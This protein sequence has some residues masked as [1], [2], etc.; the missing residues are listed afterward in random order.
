MFRCLK[1]YYKAITELLYHQTEIARLR[2]LTGYKSNQ[3]TP[4]KKTSRTLSYVLVPSFTKDFYYIP[5]VNYSFLQAKT[6]PVVVNS[7]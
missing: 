5:W 3:F 2:L 7:A 4:R 1:A 6:I